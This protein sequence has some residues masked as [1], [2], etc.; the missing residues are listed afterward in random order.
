MSHNC[1]DSSSPTSPL[2]TTSG[3]GFLGVGS[4][5]VCFLT[6][7]LT[8]PSILTRFRFRVLPL[9]S[10]SSISSPAALLAAFA[11][12]SNACMGAVSELCGRPDSETAEWEEEDRECRDKA[13]EPGAEESGMTPYVPHW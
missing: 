10:T 9:S 8:F 3:N 1:R 6:L 11:S 2:V 4:G 13:G 7:K 12:A 5:F